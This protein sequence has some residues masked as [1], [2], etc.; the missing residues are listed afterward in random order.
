MEADRIA[1]AIYGRFDDPLCDELTHFVGIPEVP[2]G[3]TGLIECDPHSE[4]RLVVEG[5]I[6]DWNDIHLHLP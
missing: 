6:L 1:L 4:R 2:K 5:Y 3:T